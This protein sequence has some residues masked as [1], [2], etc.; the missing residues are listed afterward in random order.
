[1]DD[2]LIQLLEERLFQDSYPDALDFFGVHG[3]LTAESIAQTSL[4]D[5]LFLELVFGETP[6]SPDAE[7]APLN[8]A[9]RA[10]RTAFSAALLEDLPP[11]L[12]PEVMEDEE[13]RL[14]WCSGFMEAVDGAGLFLTE[15]REQQEQIAQLLV[16]VVTFAEESPEDIP[17]ALAV[18]LLEQLQDNLLDLYLLIH[19]TQN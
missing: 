7:L 9:R 5:D 11:P 17:D 10:V 18:Q 19:A 6:K 2:S 4:D 14:N 16:P 12:P 8:E 15:A 1:M 3:L 13:A